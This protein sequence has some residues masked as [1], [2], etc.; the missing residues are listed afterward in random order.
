[1]SE[2]ELVE[3]CRQGDR[4]AFNEL[5]LQYQTKVVNISYGILGNPDDAADAAQE[6]FIK[7]YRAIERFEGKSSLSTWIYRIT[8]NVCTDILRK[9]SRTSALSINAHIGEDEKEFDI[10]DDSK[11][12]D[13]VATMNETQREVRAA[14]DS[15][16]EDYKTVLTLYDLEGLAYDEIAQIVD[17]PIGTVKSR[18]NRARAALKKKLSQKRELFL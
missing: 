16:S 8:T 17:C 7:I 4:D 13:E 6:V 15:L 9:K 5:V 1:M 12:P 11:T 2:K 18:L 10:K 3:L 14:I